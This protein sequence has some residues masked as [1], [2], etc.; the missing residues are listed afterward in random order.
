MTTISAFQG[1]GTARCSH[2]P[3]EPPVRIVLQAVLEV[4]RAD[5][6]TGYAAMV[7]AARPAPND[8]VMFA[9]EA[10]HL[11]SEGGIAHHT[12]AQSAGCTSR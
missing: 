12:C 2:H 6:T 4:F 10:V 5:L 8:F 1:A 9:A 3:V 7:S 11:R